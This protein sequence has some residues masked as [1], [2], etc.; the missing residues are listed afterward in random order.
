MEAILSSVPDLA[1][2]EVSTEVEIWKSKGQGLVEPSCE[3]SF[4]QR[5]WDT[6]HIEY[7]Q[8]NLLENADQF[9]R[10]RLLASLQPESGAFLSAIPVPSLGTHLSPDELRIAMALRTGSKICETHLC[11]CGQNVDKFGFHLLSCKFNEGRLP[12]HAAINDIICPALKSAGMASRMEPVGLNRGDG[13]KPDGIT[14]FPF[15]QG[16]ALCW[17]A[18]CVNTFSESAVNDSA[19]RAGHAASKAENAKRTKYPDLVRNYRFEPVAIETSGVFGSST[20]NIVNEIG[21]RISEKTGEKRELLWLKQRLNIAVQ[22]GNAVSIMS[23]V[24]HMTG[25]D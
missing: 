6:P 4:R 17:D 12:R 1:P 15:S 9:S 13:K 23:S 14:I 2:F 3:S 18:T 19:I 20:S 11:K 10:A 24:N 22:R 21:R 25:Y 7:T 8:K 16:K 5:A